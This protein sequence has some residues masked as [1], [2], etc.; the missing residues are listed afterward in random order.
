MNDPLKQWIRPELWLETVYHL[1]APAVPIKLNQNESAWDWPLPIK[2]AIGEKIAELAWNRYP[3]QTTEALREKLAGVLGQR[4]G[5]LV[6]ANG[7]NEILQAITT[8]TLSPGDTLCTLE[9]SFAVY[10]LLAKW[11]GARMDNSVL[12]EDF[13]LD[14]G[15]LISRSS[16]AK[17]TILC[18]PNSPTGTLLTLEVITQ[19]AGAASGL[20]IVD[21]A[22][23]QYSGV[24]ALPLLDDYPNLVIART[25]SKA[26][27]LA[28]F[29]LGYGVMGEALAEQLSKALLPFNLDAPTAVAAGILL[30]HQ[31]WVDD[32]TAEIVAERDWL[33]GRLN[34]IAG[35]K[36][37][38]SG[39]NFYLLQT[40]LG[41]HETYN[42]LLEAGILVRDVSGYT[43][44]HNFVRVT[45][46][47]PEENLRL[48]AALEKML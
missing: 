6:L 35:A 9:P 15:D 18:N 16:K 22:Y 39:A 10:P 45:V 4:A 40:E 30:D 25:F 43:G 23:V 32:R 1:P 8:L 12:G 48:V 7:S 5:Q 26:F 46:G 24:S 44:C 17:L 3:S 31:D 42:C 21:E 13:R 41:P 47:R 19:I 27:A 36:A 38:P 37:L 33:I 20:V 2:K 11:R 34:T 14:V 29:R 28:G